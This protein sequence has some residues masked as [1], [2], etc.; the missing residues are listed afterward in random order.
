MLCYEVQAG[1]ALGPHDQW[2]SDVIKLTQGPASSQVRFPSGGLPWQSGPRLPCSQSALEG[3]ERLPT[4]EIIEPFLPSDWASLGHMPAPEPIAIPGEYY[5]LIGPSVS[6]P[7]GKGGGHLP[8]GMWW[9]KPGPHQEEVELDAE[10][11]T[12]NGC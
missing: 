2:L 12:N 11:S 6:T 3:G 7:G 1:W 5:T 9:M 8:P 4:A 10:W